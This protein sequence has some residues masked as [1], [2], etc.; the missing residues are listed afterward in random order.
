MLFTKK[1][2]AA[3]NSLMKYFLYLLFAILTLQACRRDNTDNALAKDNKDVA[4]AIVR[5]FNARNWDS[6][7]FYYT[8]TCMFLSP[9]QGNEYV[10]KSKTDIIEEC[11]AS[12]AISP[13]VLR[14]LEGVYTDRN[15]LI[16]EYT[17]SGT[18]ATGKWSK[19]YCAVLT[20]KNRRV[21]RS[22]TYIV[23]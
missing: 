11:K 23:Q 21:I 18:S 13:D 22:A 14:D 17:E 8:D 15:K 5:S 20:L 7:A 12:L 6:V 1:K 3:N 2:P 19:P 4:N 9:A 16:I 10:H